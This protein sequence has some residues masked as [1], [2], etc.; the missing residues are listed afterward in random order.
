MGKYKPEDFDPQT[1]LDGPQAARML[2]ISRR[3]LSRWCAQ[4]PPKLTFRRVGNNKV[5]FRRQIIDYYLK[6]TEIRGRY[7]VEMEVTSDRKAL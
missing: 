4:K 2:G 6:T 1:L 7:H 5:Q 3:C